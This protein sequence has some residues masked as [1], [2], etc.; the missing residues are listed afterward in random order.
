MQ[1][2]VSHG[3]SADSPAKRLSIVAQ[4]RAS[5]ENSDASGMV[6][7]IDD[8]YRRQ[9]EKK[10]GEYKKKGEAA[11]IMHHFRGSQ[12]NPNSISTSK[13]DLMR[14]PVLSAE[15]GA[16]NRAAAALFVSNSSDPFRLNEDSDANKEIP[17]KSTGVVK[18]LADF[19]QKQRLQRRTESSTRKETADMYHKYSN[20]VASP[21]SMKFSSV[22]GT[23]FIF[24]TSK[25]QTQAGNDV[26]A[27]GSTVAASDTQGPRAEEK[28]DDDATED[29]QEDHQRLDE[30]DEARPDSPQSIE[31]PVIAVD[32]KKADYRGFVFVVHEQ[33]GLL[34]LHCTRKSNKG[35]HFQLPGGHVDEPEFLQAAR[36]THDANAQ[37]L[38][39]AQMGAAREL[40]EETGIDVREKLF[41]LE[42]AA[43]RN[44]LTANRNGKFIMTC[45]LKKR[46][47]FF[48]LVIDD[49]FPFDEDASKLT[50]PMTG[51]GSSLRLKLSVEHSGF[52]FEKNPERS[53][54]LLQK[55][56]GGNGSKALLMAMQ[57]DKHDH[58][59]EDHDDDDDDK[60]TKETVI[61]EKHRDTLHSEQDYDDYAGYIY[62]EQPSSHSVKLD[63][64]PADLLPPPEQKNW[65]TCCFCMK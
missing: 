2:E 40:Y 29:T 39:A 25:G 36:K 52:M 54:E 28:K 6:H 9:K 10:A 49:D 38:I 60:V 21:H 14:N 1:E 41:R 58:A 56:S 34:L 5:L 7:S 62:E 64:L 48:L 61:S 3:I 8:F 17:I 32:Y 50:A 24:D 47:Y 57:R 31:S 22:E 4:M 55:H 11:S 15:S 59:E 20:L 16:A 43:L 44:E 26:S 42:P 30:R 65:F 63:E 37:L 12:L 53:A 35:P 46:L 18:S 33:H 51:E 19:Y 13:K 27:S 23:S 45:E